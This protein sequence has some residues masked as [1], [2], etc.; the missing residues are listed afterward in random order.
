MNRIL[1][2]TLFTLAIMAC[3]ATMT[4]PISA[5]TAERG[6]PVRYPVKEVTIKLLLDAENHPRRCEVV[7]VKAVPDSFRVTRRDK[8]SA[9]IDCSLFMQRNRQRTFPP[10][11]GTRVYITTLR[12][13]AAD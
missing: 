2:R 3:P 5:G 9:R 8:L 1:R 13:R 7:E 12:S 6:G 10:K 4:A 11:P